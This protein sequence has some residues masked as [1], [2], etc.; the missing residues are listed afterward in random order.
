MR[1]TI[2]LIASLCFMASTAWAAKRASCV[3]GASADTAQL[4]N[5]LVLCNKAVVEIQKDNYTCKMNISLSIPLGSIC[6]PIVKGVSGSYTIDV[7]KP[8]IGMSSSVKTKTVCT[9][10]FT[11][12]GQKS[13][14]GSPA[15]DIGKN[16]LYKDFAGLNKFFAGSNSP[17]QYLDACK[18]DEVTIANTYNP[19]F[20][21]TKLCISSKDGVDLGPLAIAGTTTQCVTIKPISIFKDKGKI[22]LPLYLPYQ[23]Q[24]A[25]LP[26]VLQGADKCA[27]SINKGVQQVDVKL[28]D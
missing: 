14:S 7:T 19:G 22:N 28:T 10:P 24:S 6:L 15:I 5:G 16:N 13:I 27:A 20:N 11:I 18:L 21:G 2:L 8:E 23:C 9:Q 25:A 26:L 12:S 1:K 4:A 17:A 3:D